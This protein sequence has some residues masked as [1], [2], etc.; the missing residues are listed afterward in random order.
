M[1]R[2][3][4]IIIR[5][6]CH[7]HDRLHEVSGL[8][9]EKLIYQYQYRIAEAATSPSLPLNNPLTTT[10]Y[11]AA[12]AFCVV[13]DYRE[14]WTDGWKK[15]MNKAMDKKRML[16]KMDSQ[17]KARRTRRLDQGKEVLG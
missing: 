8:Q 5:V 2:R 11:V 1:A 16:I 14:K 3:D 10:D 17:S 15:F 13:E 12:H 7:K 9:A 4:G 6:Y